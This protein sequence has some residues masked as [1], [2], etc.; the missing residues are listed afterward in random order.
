MTMGFQTFV[1]ATFALLMAVVLNGC[2]SLQGP[3]PNGGIPICLNDPQQ[4]PDLVP[5]IVTDKEDLDAGKACRFCRE[6][7]RDLKRA[8]EVSVRNQGGIGTHREPTPF[9]ATLGSPN[10]PASVTRVTFTAS[11]GS[12]ATV[13]MPT[14][15]LS[16]GF[17]VDLEPVIYPPFCI[18]HDCHITISVDANKTVVESIEANN[19]ASCFAPVIL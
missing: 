4:C 18:T 3:P 16:V 17:S 2:G 11:D 6:T 9:L 7:E 5:A 19:T 10:A 14:P 8:I 13:D 1:L 12:I 15:A